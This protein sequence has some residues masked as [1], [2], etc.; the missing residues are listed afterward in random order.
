MDGLSLKVAN[1]VDVQIVKILDYKMI[2]TFRIKENDEERILKLRFDRVD[3]KIIIRLLLYYQRKETN[4]IATF[5]TLVND[6]LS[7]KRKK[8]FYSAINV[9]PRISTKFD[10]YT[11]TDLFM[12]RIKMTADSSTE[13]TFSKMS[14]EHYENNVYRL[15]YYETSGDTMSAFLLF[16]YS[17]LSNR[18]LSGILGWI[19]KAEEDCIMHPNKSVVAGQKEILKKLD[20]YH[21]LK[22]MIHIDI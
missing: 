21:K 1:C 8:S 5:S 11:R 10:D 19:Y 7:W 18:I 3:I 14:V 16:S 9:D 17:G 6:V 15:V 22:N 2:V 20:N 4:K 12:N 13:R